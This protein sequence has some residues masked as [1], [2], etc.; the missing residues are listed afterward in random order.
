MGVTT[1]AILFFGIDLGEDEGEFA[2]LDSEKD[3]DASDYIAE[4]MGVPRP[5]CEYSGNEQLYSA[6]WKKKRE[7]MEQLGCDI[8]YHCT[9]ELPLY[10]VYLTDFIITANRGYPEKVSQVTVR[11]PSEENIEK[12][13]RFCELCDIDWEQPS[14]H[15]ASYWS[16]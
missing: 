14:W 3:L 4:K 15:L 13:K 12:L 11:Y 5:D 8:D 16:C 10:Y 6:Y 7:I 9:S 1:D 2:W